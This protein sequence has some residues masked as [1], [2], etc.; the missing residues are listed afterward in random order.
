MRSSILRRNQEVLRTCEASTRRTITT[1]S[2]RTSKAPLP[3]CQACSRKLLQPPAQRQSQRRFLSSAATQTN[4]SS[5]DSIRSNPIPQTHYEFFPKTLPQGPPP[6]GRFHIDIRELRREFL[7][8]QAVA[9][10]DRHPHNLKTRAEATSARINE[11]YKT[12]QNPLLRTQYLLS[13]RG[14]DVAEDE[15]AKVEDPEL[16]MEVLDA[17]EEIEN[18]REE[19]EL[20]EMKRINEERIE[21]SEAILDAAFKRDDIEGAKSEA[22][23]LRYWVNIKES[24]DAWER[25]KP[26][27]LVH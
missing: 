12:L 15:T 21:R 20:E 16:L 19:E 1:S 11:A 25:G 17:R 3:I 6:S 22:V 18:A 9:H 23:R 14:I 4:P 27:V 8:L 24:L 26:V 5:D 2:S 7:Q 13:L 10:P